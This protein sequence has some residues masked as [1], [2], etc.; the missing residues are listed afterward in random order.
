[1]SK[2]LGQ[3][4]Y[5]IDTPDQRKSTKHCDVNM[6]KEYHDRAEATLSYA[7]L[8]KAFD[9]VEIENKCL[10]AMSGDIKCKDNPVDGNYEF[11]VHVSPKMNNSE[12]IRNIDKKVQH[13]SAS[14]RNDIKQLI[15]EFQ[16][17]FPDSPP[18]TSWIKHDVDVGDVRPIKQHPY[19]VNPV[20]DPAMSKEVDY[21][22]KHDIIE[23]SSSSWSSPCILV[24]KPDGSNRFVTDFKRVNSVTKP[25]SFPIP[26]LLDCIDK[27]GNAKYISVFDWL[28]RYWQLP[29]YKVAPFG[30]RNSSAISQRLI[31]RVTGKLEK[32]EA[33]VDDVATW[34]DS[35]QEHLGHIRNLFIQVRAA[36]L[37]INLGKPQVLYLGHEAGNGTVKPNMA[38]AA[39]IALFLSQTDRKFVMRFLG[40]AEF[41]R[42]FCQNFADVVAPLTN[43]LKKEVKFIW[44]P[45]EQ[46]AFKMV[47]SMLTC[48]PVLKAPDFSKPF[49]LAVDASAI[50]MGTVLMQVDDNGI[51]HPVSFYS[52]KLVKHQQNYSVVEKEALSLLSALR[53]YNVYLG[54]SPHVTIVYSDHNPL[55]FVQRMKTDNQRL[56]RWSLALQEYNVEVRH[57][58]GCDN[59]VADSLSRIA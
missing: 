36:G 7:D 12:W 55:V 2:K 41:F 43:L 17:I 6:L 54:S 15:H 53:H 59:V 10:M 27:I 19:R 5:V 13:L 14:Q 3:V 56:L 21:M 42:R 48:E 31:N 49:Q 50:G 11:D 23:P 24:A 28:K 1:M 16:D 39:A 29:K 52:K 57:I 9:H 46:E 20:K 37:G 34:A 47:K 51:D 18:K 22:L 25:D 26:R 33:Y 38:K 32:T 8:S 4:N 30:M 40:M 35:W 58:K 44:T 45:V